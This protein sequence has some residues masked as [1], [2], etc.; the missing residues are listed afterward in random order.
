M[1]LDQAV[2]HFG[3]KSE[4]ARRLGLHA[5]G[6]SMWIARGGSVPMRVQWQLELGTNGKLKA[7]AAPLLPKT[8]K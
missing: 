5:S 4:L 6:I 8:H 2:Q 1:T 7:D 3:S